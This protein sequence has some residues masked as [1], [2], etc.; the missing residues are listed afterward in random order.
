MQLK[1]WLLYDT[2]N[3]QFT[4]PQYAHT[5][6][7]WVDTATILTCSPPCHTAI[8]SRHCDSSESLA[9]MYFSCS[10]RQIDRRERWAVITLTA[11]PQTPLRL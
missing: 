9:G 8:I 2:L 11:T 3:M 4:D 10:R 1:V 7:I 5:E 6:I